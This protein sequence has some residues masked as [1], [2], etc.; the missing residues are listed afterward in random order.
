MNTRMKRGGWLGLVAG[1][2]LAGGAS[3]ALGVVAEGGTATTYVLNDT[4]YMVHVFTDTGDAELKIVAGGTVD[5]L[6]VGGGGGGGS[7]MGGGGGAGGFIYR[8]GFSVEPGVVKITVGA[9]G[10]GAPAGAGQPRGTSGGDSAFGSLVAKGGGGGASVHD[11]NRSPAADGGSGGGA[12]GRN[13]NAG[14]GTPDQGHPGANSKGAYYPGGGGGAGGPGQVAPAHG[15]PGVESAILGRPLFFAG[16]GGGSGYTEDGGNGGLGGGGGGAI[17]TTTG[18]VGLNNGGPGGGGGRGQQANTPGGNAGANTGGGGGGGGHYNANNKGGDG[19]SGIVVVRYRLGVSC[20]PATDVTATTATLRG[21]LRGFAGLPAEVTVFWGDRDGGVTGTWANSHTWPKGEWEDG[22][23][24]EWPV[25]DL[26][27]DRTYSYTFRAVTADRDQTAEP[28]AS[29]ITGAV[30]IEKQSDASETGLTPGTFTVR[31]PRT[32]R[33]RELTV[34]YQ[35]SGSADNGEDY[36]PLSGT[37]TIP[38]GADT[39]HLTVTPILDYLA[40]PDETVTVTLAEGPYRIG[41]K[42]QAS[43]TLADNG[44][45]LFPAAAEPTMPFDAAILCGVLQSRFQGSA[46][47]FQA[48]Y[49]VAGAF[50]CLADQVRRSMLS[51]DPAVV[52]RAV[53][54]GAAFAPYA[55][56]LRGTYFDGANHENAILDRRDPGILIEAG[57]FPHP[58]GRQENV[59]ALWTGFLDIQR[60][61]AYKFHVAKEGGTFRIS[62]ANQ[63]LLSHEGGDAWSS[64]VTLEPGLHPFHATFQRGTAGVAR[65]ELTWEGPGFGRTALGG[66]LRT[67]LTVEEALAVAGVMPALAGADAQADAAARQVLHKTDPASRTF[68]INALY[69]GPPAV[70]ATAVEMLAALGDAAAAALIVEQ[71]EAGTA[72]LP[73]ATLLAA[74]ERLA[75]HLDDKACRWLAG[76]VPIKDTPENRPWLAVL[77]AVLER[78][79]GGEAEAFGNLTGQ[80]GGNAALA[81]LAKDMLASA[82]PETVDWACQHAGPFAPFLP[83]CRGRFYDGRGFGRLVAEQR[84][85][86]PRYDNGQFPH[87]AQTNVSASWHGRLFVEKPGEYTFFVRADDGMRLWLDG[88]VVV[89]AWMHRAGQDISGTV[90]LDKG[91]HEIDAAAWQADDQ[92]YADVNWQGPDIGRQRLDGRMQAHPLAAD[93]AALRGHLQNLAA[94]DA[95]AVEQAKKAIAGYGDL[96]KLLLRNAAEH[97][98]GAVKEQAAAL[99]APT[100]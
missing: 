51:K 68:L 59:S 98:T 70:A 40:E 33:A 14:K 57:K 97:E 76:R 4:E 87:T 100:P 42:A 88:K 58:D 94:A 21:R 96:G 11:A 64:P 85:P 28:S 93:L 1:F 82:D 45:L 95:P 71:L 32:A 73:E 16:G 7:D 19:G 2:L 29:F 78:K 66:A 27:P 62:V 72:P 69:N 83:G 23:V 54:Y 3:Q 38:A 41:D 34:R 30:Q 61:G 22:S 10:A 31:R 35:V 26:E 24:L 65:C 36:H 92:G 20:E 84:P 39:A 79:C 49:G 63:V 56:G 91:W 25:K 8:E 60:P 44:I 67:P 37:L 75:V 9:G 17:G 52:A 46:E 81:E 13:A 47:K 15:G 77:Y 55:Y 43:L 53:A 74:L 80:P 89:D 18:G 6:V 90:T 50:D 99:L 5:V 48:Y 12:S 86:S